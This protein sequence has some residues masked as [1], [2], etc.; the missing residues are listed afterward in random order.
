MELSSLFWA[1]LGAFICLDLLIVFFIWK[2]VRS[3]RLS[4][5]QKKYFQSLV[6]KASQKEC[7]ARIF[8]YDKILGEVLSA[9]SYQG[10]IGQQ[11]H[12]SKHRYGSLVPIMQKAHRYR[13]KLAHESDFHPTEASLQ[14][15]AESFEYIFK[16]LL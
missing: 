7:E 14:K 1:F 16:Q 6:K 3:R 13:N 10:T 5:S 15:N 9:F 8:S 4:F 2:K 11:I 12:K